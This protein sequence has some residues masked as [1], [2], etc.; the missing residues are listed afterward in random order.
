MELYSK[1]SDMADVKIL[2]TG[3]RKCNRL[4]EE[5]EKAIRESG[6]ESSLTKVEKLDEIASYGVMSTP[7]LVVD[8]RVKSTGSIPK[9]S[10]IA[11]WI[12]EAAV[13]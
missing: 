2:G 7:A 6:V 4:Y 1:E 9:A 3:C 5:A 12:R 8:G 10:R 11:E 13:K